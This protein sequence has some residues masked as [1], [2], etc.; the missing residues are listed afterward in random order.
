MIGAR[1][2]KSTGGRTISGC[3]W[4]NE[5][6]TTGVENQQGWA[7][8]LR[9]DTRLADVADVSFRSQYSTPGFGEIQDVVQQRSL[10][11]NF[12][13]DISSTLHLDKFI[14][15]DIGLKI[16]MFVSQEA[17]VTTPE[18]DPFNADVPLKAALSSMDE[19]DR[20]SYRDITRASDQRRSL[21]FANVH[22]ERKAGDNT[23]ARVYDIENFA[24]TYS[25]NDR[26]QRNSTIDHQLYQYYRGNLSY[27]FSTT[28]QYITP[29]KW[30]S[31]HPYLRWLREA[32]INFFP[33]AFNFSFD[34]NR[35]FQ[36]KQVRNMDF[37]AV[38]IA[39]VFEKSYVFDQNYGMQWSLSSDLQLQYS[40]KGFS[41]IDEPDGDIETWG[42]KMEIWSNILHLG[43]LKHFTQ[44]LEAQY[45]VPLHKIPLFEGVRAGLTYRGGYQWRAGARFG[46]DPLNNVVENSR[47]LSANLG[48]DMLSW[49]NQVPF[50]KPSGQKGIAKY[51]VNLLTM[52]KSVNVDLT[53][54]SQTLLPGFSV[55]PQALGMNFQHMA[56]GWTF[57]LGSQDPDIRE[58]ASQ[59]GWMYK[60]ALLTQTFRQQSSERLNI[61]ARLLP[62]PDISIQLTARRS[63]R[64]GYQE[65]FRYDASADKHITSSPARNG[66]YT[67]SFFSIGSAFLPVDKAVAFNNF[68]SYRSVIKTKL[69]A[70]NRLGNYDLNA[71]DVLI[72][73][74]LAAY[75]NQDPDKQLL[76]PFP[77]IPWPNWQ[78]SYQGLSK[79]PGLRDW[80]AACTIT[81]GYSSM[82]TVGNFANSL[83]Y[84]D[85]YLDYGLNTY[86]QASFFAN[87]EL[88]PFYIINRV[89]VVE[90]FVPLVGVNLV[91]K[92]TFSLRFEFRKTREL[93]LNI[94]SIQLEEAYDEDLSVDA[95]YS[96]TGI[97]LPVYLFGINRV[98]DNTLSF[99]LGFSVRNVKAQQRTLDGP[100][101]TTGG[102]ID[103]QYRG[104]IDYD[105]NQFLNVQLYMNYG[106]ANPTLTTA[107]PR[108]QNAVGLRL[109][110]NWSQ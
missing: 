107:F 10:E 6:R 91:F 30:V 1:N 35:T 25:Y 33:N 70:K 7:G 77:N 52:L 87:D 71:Q 103:A 34:L 109:R 54:T 62:L 18:Y 99:R 14:P 31:S 41:L 84:D 63:S 49:Y 20:A 65:L 89:S 72:P 48:V 85:L 21:N 108:A 102:S 98:L 9:M 55:M 26:I 36:R 60:N 73:A 27:D 12:V 15:V 104:S 97:K 38:D 95:S 45:N 8:N 83:L 76:N 2:P 32:D 61:Q 3:L 79:L 17:S 51:F 42:Q 75:A 90:G 64:G 81:H 29:F 92:N 23:K 13:Y 74:F 82:Y 44:D 78:V 110:V 39:P 93:N 96:K 11:Q 101:L 80:L 50:L 94:S 67:T 43:R 19:Q 58:I 47:E 16:P 68:S 86:R 100:N 56:P 28:A 57:I 69:D 37:S 46:T 59:N 40:A 106:N 4:A 53:Q 88:V 22:K 5:L 105:L 24:F 66:T